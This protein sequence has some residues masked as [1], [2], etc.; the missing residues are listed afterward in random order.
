M[1]KLLRKLHEDAQ[2]EPYVDKQYLFAHGRDPSSVSAQRQGYFRALETATA[3]YVGNLSFFTTEEVIHELFSKAGPVK[4]V[5][6]GLNRS[7]LTPC[8]FAFVEFYTHEAAQASVDYISGTHLDER[9]VNVE[10]DR[11][12]EEGRQ[13][14]RGKGGGQIRDDSRRVYDPSRPVEKHHAPRAAATGEHAPPKAKPEPSM[15]TAL[16]GS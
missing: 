14:G 7:D 9:A 15:D 8:G 11:G 13:Y 6:M 16:S 5:R 12:F 4:R 2:S 10:L 3:V 1:S